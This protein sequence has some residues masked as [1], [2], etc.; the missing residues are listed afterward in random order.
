MALAA[1]RRGRPLVLVMSLEE[2]LLSLSPGHWDA[3]FDVVDEILRSWFALSPRRIGLDAE[4]VM[5]DSLRE[6]Y[7]R[8]G[9]VLPAVAWQN[10]LLPANRLATADGKL[11]FAVENQGVYSWAVDPS[12]DRC[13]VWGR[14]ENAD[15]WKAEEP[16][17]SLFLLQFVLL[18]AIFRAPYG[19]GAAWL[20]QAATAVLLDE[21]TELPFGAWH[22]PQHPARF[23]VRREALLFVCPN[24]GNANSVWLAALDREHVAFA[25]SHAGDGWEDVRL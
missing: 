14:F 22:W 1:P 17:L 9:A 5:P 4:Q 6:F 24:G 13:S 11:V 25:R 2:R 21:S 12:A 20:G 19:A 23:H 16:Q 3:H 15:P 8:F 10:E 7:S 18:E